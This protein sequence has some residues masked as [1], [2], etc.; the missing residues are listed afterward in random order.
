MAASKKYVYFFG[1]G[2]AEGKGTDRKTLG[3]KG[4]GLAEMTSIGLPVPA[5][6]TISVDT[7]EYYW[8]NGKKW[9]AGLDKEIK[10]QL[11]QLE[12]TTKKKLGDPKDP[13]LVSVRSGAARSMPGMMETILNL[14]LNDKSVEG[15]ATATNNPRFAWD[16]YRRFLQMYSTTAV[17]LSKELLEDKL[18][19]LKAPIGVKG[20]HEIPAENL[21]ELCGEFK[22]FFREQTGKDFPQDPWTQLVGAI[23]AVFGSWNAE[24]AVTYRRVEKI[25]DLKGTGVIVQQMVFGN[26]GDDSGSGVCFPRDP[27]TGENLFYGDMLVNAQGEDVVAGIRTPIKLSDLGKKMPAIYDQLCAVRAILE[28]AQKIEEIHTACAGDTDDAHVRRI[29]NA[30]IAGQVGGGIGTPL[31]AI[32][33]YLGLE[34]VLHASLRDEIGP[35]GYTARANLTPG[36]GY[37][38]DNRLG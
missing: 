30:Q 26:M 19:H 31:A 5:G 17:G 20:D 15:L 28:G 23:N 6:F 2:K 32:R 16:A 36:G 3:G 18:H 7:C 1:A 34:F 35:S 25:T 27:S 11:A 22:A 12:K 14:G 37:W 13:L 4:A 24:K 33:Q 10:A 21:K 29:L 9:P 38:L 8:A